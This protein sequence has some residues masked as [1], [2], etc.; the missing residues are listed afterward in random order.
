MTVLAHLL[1]GLGLG[2]PW[3]LGWLAAVAI[4]VLIHLWYRR[5]REEHRWAATRLLMAAITKRRRRLR[6]GQWFLLALRMLLIACVVLAVAQPFRQSAGLNAAAGQPVHHIIVIDASWSMDYRP[7]NDDRTR[8]DHA[9]KL[10]ASIV[11][12]SPPGD[13]FS[14]ILMADRPHT[15]VRGPVFDADAVAKEVANLRRL[16]GGSDVLATLNEVE[17]IAAEAAEAFPQLSHTAV[18]LLTDLGATSWNVAVAG[19]GKATSFRGQVDRLS[20]MT[21]LNVIDVGQTETDNLSVTQL[22]TSDLL[23]TSSAPIRWTANVE[24]HSSHPHADQPVELYVDGRLAKQ[25]TVTLAPHG[26]QS[27][28]FTHTFPQPGDHTVEVRLGPDRLPLDNRRYLALRLKRAIDVLC[29]GGSPQATH[30]LALA[31]NPQRSSAA[32]IQPREVDDSQFEGMDLAP[33]DCVMFSNVKQF[34]AAEARQL[35]AYLDGGGSTIFFLGSNVRASSYNRTLSGQGEGRL[36]LLPV[37][38]REIAP[39]GRYTF[40]PLG[41]RHPSIAPFRRREQ[42]GL[43]TT[44]IRR[45]WR[46]Q[47]SENSRNTTPDSSSERSA[48]TSRP[49][50]ET[51]VALAL[52]NGNPA[53]VEGRV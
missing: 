22:T 45:Y 41:Y 19:D 51:R 20:A 12:Q 28:D 38:L 43:L 7:G 1:L 42:A 5:Q 40:D 53:I 31:L 9:K 15:I 14:L 26:R 29:V 10:A 25:T 17:A 36:H 52:H 35:K 32:S 39:A 47:V 13:G 2:S 46:L 23:G 44:P 37:Q 50:E 30:Y 49:I 11:Q 16:D 4:P 21:R 18:T 27:I 6:I 34:T 8:F 3:M 33:F 48:P 24:N